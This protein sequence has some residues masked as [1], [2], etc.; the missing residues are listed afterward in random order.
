MKEILLSL[1]K[2]LKALIK[3]LQAQKPQ[4]GFKE[5]ALALGERESNNNY[6][7][8]NVY[9]YMGRW[10]F[11]MARLCDLGYTE[12]KAGTSGYSN[13]AFQWKEGYSQEYFLNTPYFQDQIFAE[14]CNS[15]IKNINARFSN[16]LG[17][18][19]NNIKITLSG[20]VAGAHLS[21]I[22]GVNNF[23]TKAYDSSD[24]NGTKTSDYIREFS[25]YDL[26]KGITGSG[27][28]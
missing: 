20:L 16:Y 17:K 1:I 6:T 4:K 10:Q 25:K 3:I 8:I 22:G 28:S 27:L 26:S 11:G 7:A 5:F 13:S 19:V 9:N 15:H 12:R 24:V 21:G 18:V 23:L 2:I 14:H